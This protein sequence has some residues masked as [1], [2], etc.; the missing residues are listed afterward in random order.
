MNPFFLIKQNTVYDNIIGVLFIVAIGGF[1]GRFLFRY[2]EMGYALF[3]KKPIYTHLYLRPKTITSKQEQILVS[4]SHFYK[5]L[6]PK[7]RQYFRHR[8]A[9]FMNEKSFVGRQDMEITEE[10]KVLISATAVMLTFGFRNFL[11]G[12]VD[13]I[14]V[15]PAAFYSN[16]NN[17]LHKGE[18][19]PKLKTV[20]LSWEDFVLGID[21]SNDNL[22]LGVHEFA[23]AIHMNSIKYQDINGALFLKSFNELVT[24][25]INNET[26]KQD[27]I[28]SSYLRGYAYTNQYEFMA[29]VIEH[30]IETPSE[31]RSQFPQLYNKTK[32]ML[33]FNFAG[34]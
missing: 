33:N 5:R 16:T 21:V 24:L 4:K 18:F 34:Y 28:E 17:S 11:I 13:T 23:H 32:Q 9:L 3:K 8:L 10:V 19:N 27:L 30:F 1:L 26:L 29:V 14:L 2:I 22:N 6:S 31:F 15:Y 20:V 25:L 12:M 7:K